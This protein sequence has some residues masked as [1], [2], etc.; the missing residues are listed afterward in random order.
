MSSDQ[1]LG[2]KYVATVRKRIVERVHEV[3][4]SSKLKTG[5]IFVEVIPEKPHIPLLHVY[6]DQYKIAREDSVEYHSILFHDWSEIVCALGRAYVLDS[7]FM[8]YAPKKFESE[9]EHVLALS[10][11]F[12]LS[13]KMFRDILRKNINSGNMHRLDILLFA[14]YRATNRGTSQIIRIADIFKEVQS[15]QEKTH[16]VKYCMD[17]CYDAE[18]Q[19]S[20]DYC[21]EVLND[22]F[23]FE[24]VGVIRIDLRYFRSKPKSG[25]VTW[26]VKYVISP[27]LYNLQNQQKNQSLLEHLIEYY[28][29]KIRT[30]MK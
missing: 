1:N 12:Y 29:L 4:P 21:I 7:I 17:E 23:A 24:A 14:L 19:K 18:N 16:I 28:P 20:F 13:R 9:V 10:R 5:D 26:K 2:K 6:R 11:K 30:L 8:V 22:M 3:Y 15:L 25:R 27:F